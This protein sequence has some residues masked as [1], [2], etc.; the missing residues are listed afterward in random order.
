MPFAK[1]AGSCLAF[2]LLLGQTPAFPR[3]A[4]L[5]TPPPQA[6]KVPASLVQSIKAKPLA[7]DQEP[8]TYLDDSGTSWVLCPMPSDGKIRIRWHAGP[9]QT[10]PPPIGTTPFGACYGQGALWCTAGDDAHR[11]IELFRF[12]PD[13]PSDGWVKIGSFDGVGGAPLLVVPLHRKDE[14]FGLSATGFCEPNGKHASFA[15]IFRCAAGRLHL[16]SCKDMPFEGQASVVGPEW[17]DFTKSRQVQDAPTQAASRQNG[18]WFAKTDPPIL[19]PTLILPSISE[20]YIVIGAASAGVLWVY[21]LRNGQL[22]R[23]INLTGLDEKNLTRLSPLTH[24]ILGT[25]FTPGGDLIVASLDPG[26]IKLTDTL[27]S[28]GSEPEDRPLRQRD[29]DFFRKDF[30]KVYW[31]RINLKTG[32]REHIE[33]PT[34]FPDRLPRLLSFATFHFLVDAQGEIRSNAYRPWATV[35]RRFIQQAPM[36]RPADNPGAPLP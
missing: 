34:E 36:A 27:D 3:T 26:L 7:R 11:R 30:K 33:A 35:L 16:Q 23:T 13:I 4:G 21:G 1:P 6:R 18:Y 14:Y 5:P 17:I 15:G 25:G 20:D 32:I 28:N 29:F 10:I 31:W 12:D 24:V 2:L 22:R 8:I 9:V 19:T